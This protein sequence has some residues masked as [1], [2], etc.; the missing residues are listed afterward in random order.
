MAGKTGTTDDYKD[1]WFVGFTPNMA[2]GVYVGYD[3]PRN[4]GR[5][6]TGGELAAP[7]FRDFMAEAMKGKPPTPFN[8][9]GGM[10]PIWIDPKTGVKV[11]GG[12]EGAIV[13]AFKPGTG[14]NLITSVIG[15]DSDVFVD[16]EGGSQDF[17]AGRGG[18]F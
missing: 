5:N 6:A 9:P 11:S 1:A 7:I 18:L 8:I 15:V 13:E 16:L 10:T 14:P 2:V 17:N 12:G 3:T 4:M